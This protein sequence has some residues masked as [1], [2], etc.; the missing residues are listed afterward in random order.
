MGRIGRLFSNRK[1]FK[2]HAR[3]HRYQEPD[4]CFTEM[5]PKVSI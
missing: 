5:T 1:V 3:V 4:K 2:S